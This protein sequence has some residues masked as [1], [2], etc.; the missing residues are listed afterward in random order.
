MATTHRFDI[1]LVGGGL[2]SGLIALSALLHMPGT[3]IALVER[4]EKPGGDQ[5][6]CVHAADIPETARGFVDPLIVQRWE[7]YDVRLPSLARTVAGPY[8][9]I[10]SHRFAERVTETLARAAGCQV[11]L[12]RTAHHVGAHAV[13]LD[14]GRVLN[15]TL[16]IDARGPSLESA[17]QIACGFQKHV[18]LELDFESEHRLSRPLLMD[19]AVPQQ[20]GFRF[21][22]V[23][24]CGP[25]RLLIQDTCVS[26][27]ATLDRDAA[28]LSIL[29]YA[30]RFGSVT[31][32]ARENSGLLP[33]P[34]KSAAPEPGRSPL[35]AGVRGGFF[36]PA[37]GESLPVAVRLAQ[38]V[39]TRP[40]H[41]VFDREFERL[42]HA[43]GAQFRFAL[44]LNRM[45]FHWFAP[46]DMWHA[47]ERF[48]QLPDAVIHR[49]HALETTHGDRAR[50]LV[51]RPPRGMSLGAALAAVRS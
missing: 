21:F 37:T 51:G 44:R 12:G 38:H 40:P 50:L 22:H 31:A 24:P 7:G 9:A 29:Q 49:F 16:V 45:L 33:M 10:S 3:R 11:L 30:E 48:Y 2:Q 4:R 42:C 18:G 41:A 13:I 35:V 19:A 5:T 17:P 43:H 27:S 39:G 34:W 25:T 8:A 15:A 23:M 1:V 14:D 6:W 20:G 47:F 36:H 32:I 26:R 28:R 46:H